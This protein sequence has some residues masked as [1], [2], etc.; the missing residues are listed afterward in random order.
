MRVHMSRFLMCTSLAA[1]IT[2]MAAA[3]PVDF[4]GKT[5]TMI[6]G[7]APGGGTDLLGRAIASSISKFLPGQPTIVVQNMPG[8]EG[9][10]AAN[11]FA[12]RVSPDGQTIAMGAAT[13]TDPLYFRRP[14]S[15]YVP[16]TFKVIGGANRGGT[17]LFIRNGALPRLHDATANPVIMGSLGGVPRAGMQ[18]A[19]WGVRLLGW[20]VKWVVGYPGTSQLFMA[21]NR[22]E[23]EMTSTAV[24]TQVKELMAGGNFSILSQSGSVKDGKFVA[25]PAFGA[26]PLLSSLVQGKIKDPT[27]A[28]SFAYWS[29]I[30]SM[31]VWMSLPPK[32]PDEIVDIYR[33]AFNAMVQDPD[34]LR[35]IEKIEH[36]LTFRSHE[37]VEYLLDMLDKT[38]P[39][40][41]QFISSMLRSQGLTVN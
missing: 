28:S 35:M 12:Q 41:I 3:D 4:R 1:S 24:P 29:A 31:D 7:Y 14:Q 16:N 23:I 39:Q 20:N 2:T 25:Q 17:A 15:H 5:V 38:P 26:A 9:T 6:I 33:Q 10:N 18:A 11:F 30:N 22:G 13:Q 8:A 34:F 37:D 21:L 27:T 19:A 40:A 32:T 36:N